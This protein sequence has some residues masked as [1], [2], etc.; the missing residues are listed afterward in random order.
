M[1]SQALLKWR[2]E[3]KLALDQI[4]GMHQKIGGTGRGR[5]VAMEQLNRAYTVLLSSEF[6]G[7]CRDLHSEATQQIIGQLGGPI[8]VLVI[9]SAQFDHAR[10]LDH[11][12]PNPGNV[13]ADFSRFGLKFIDEVKKRDARNEKRLKMLDDELNKW[14]NA[15]AHNDHKGRGLG[16][17]FPILRKIQR[18]RSACNQLS[19]DFDEIMR[20]HLEALLGASPW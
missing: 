6:Q 20:L 12:N 2:S 16:R 7:F 9:V 18:W 3:R 1:P 14:R 15:I 4:E 8:A 17:A 10:K 5:R 11:Y 19:S 13:G